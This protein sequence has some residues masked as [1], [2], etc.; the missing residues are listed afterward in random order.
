[1]RDPL[2]LV[3]EGV[4]NINGLWSQ[5]Q[6]IFLGMFAVSFVVMVICVCR[7]NILGVADRKKEKEMVRVCHLLM[8]RIEKLMPVYRV[9]VERYTKH[10]ERKMFKDTALAETAQRIP[11]EDKVRAE[12]D[13][14]LKDSQSTGAIAILQLQFESLKN[15][16]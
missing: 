1:M 2:Q 9:T 7:R 5:D 4:A 16:D 14:R 12:R 3:L 13:F 11:Y 8:N 10:V 15:K 6:S